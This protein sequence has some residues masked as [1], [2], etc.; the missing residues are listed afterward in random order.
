[1]KPAQIASTLEIAVPTVRAWAAE[2][3]LFLTSAGAGGEGRHRD[4]NDLDLR[5]LYFVREQ[6]R[7]GI[8]AEEIHAAL[9]QL[10]A[11]DWEGLPYVPERP[12][13]AQ[14]PM[15]PAVAADMA[16]DT[17]RRS[18]LREIAMLQER[19]DDMQKRLDAKDDEIKEVI[20]NKNQE[21]NELTRKLAEVETELKLYR[22]GRLK[23]E[24]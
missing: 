6:K 1:M 7:A 16:L 14:V 22:S 17:E 13:M 10:Q 9:R 5:V 24:E 2:Y 11:T 8:P 20:N 19:I 18:L 15:V 12:N 3:R 23:P 21:V 4:F